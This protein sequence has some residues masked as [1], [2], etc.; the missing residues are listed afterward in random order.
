[1]KGSPSKARREIRAAPGT[2]RVAQ[3]AAPVRLPPPAGSGSGVDHVW[4]NIR[5]FLPARMLGAACQLGGDG[6]AAHLAG[7]ATTTIAVGP[8][9]SAGPGWACVRIRPD[10]VPFPDDSFDLVAIDDL[11]AAGRRPI[12]VL[13]EAIRLCRPTGT[14][15]IGFRRFGP[16]GRA[17]RELTSRSRPTVVALPGP[18][19]PAFILDPSD[20]RAARYFVRR[21]AFA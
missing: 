17:R 15:V 18:R 8:D 16:G 5:I 21:M 12:D 4:A 10:A 1:M 19:R 11:R 9:V 2:G 20:G 6:V 7:F 13:D 14:I 3:R